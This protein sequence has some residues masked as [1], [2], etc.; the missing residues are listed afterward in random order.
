MEPFCIVLQLYPEMDVDVSYVLRMKDEVPTKLQY[1][2]FRS[3][4]WFMDR[5]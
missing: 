5:Y 1:E 3:A 4:V 2:I